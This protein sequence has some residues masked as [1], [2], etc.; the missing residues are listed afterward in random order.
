MK[1]CPTLLLTVALSAASAAGAANT[2][3]AV[4]LHFVGAEFSGGAKD[5]FGSAYDGEQVNT[6]YAAP[7]KPRCTMQVQ[8]VLPT[9]PAGPLF[10]HLK[11]RDDDGPRQCDIRIDL[12][13]QA[14]FAGPNEFPARKFETRQFAI[15]EGA[16]QAGTNTL[17]ITCREAQGKLGNPPW[18]QVANCVIA[19]KTFVLRPD[20]HKS[21]HVVLAAESRPFPEPLPAGQQPGFKFRGTKGWAWTPEQYL[22]EIPWLAKFK[23]NFLM[24]CYLSMFDLE[25]CPN[26]G[27]G[28]AN[29]WWEEL[30]TD[31]KAAYAKVVRACQQQG[32]EF[33]FGMNP[34]LA[35]KRMV[36]DNSPDSVNLLFK[37]Y[38][39]MQSLGVKWFNV[40]LDDISQGINASSQAKV[41]N[42]LFQRLR[43]KDPQAQ[44]I[45][46]PTFYWGD[47]TLPKQQPYLEILA[48]ELDKDVY[49]FWTGD[50]V[51]GKVTRRA[52]ETFRRISGHRLFLWDNYPVNDNQPTL[53]LGPVVDRDADLGEV[54]DG[55]MGNPHC[56]QNEIN[57]LP[58]ATCADYAYN[59]AAYDP[60]RSIGQ[61]ICQVGATSGQRQV[62]RDLVE[63]YPGM[64]IYSPSRGT[65]F[66]SLQDQC[67][68]ILSGP[69]SRQAALAYLEHL[70]GLLQ[71]LKS[72][73]S[74]GYQPEKATLENDLQQVAKK[75]AARYP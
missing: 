2:P 54:I 62:L 73:F 70:R 14:L 67:D 17:A 50:A 63:T 75:I 74:D 69:H 37:H 59:P 55:Y 43:A 5:R 39:W 16:L 26:W 4:L 48:R 8:F 40:S 19:A 44:L 58:L 46:C 45:L 3:P 52:A 18:F 36:N 51:V 28:E 49:V 41:V 22:A 15:P 31:K 35:S 7:T 56:K 11:A 33:C 47:G 71:R 24:N 13:G 20:L 27:N 57:R 66:N 25:H 10:V 12:N 61:A 72:E 21:F 30:P 42:D 53:H 32:I 29:R 60:L 6:I 64:L 1:F 65:G 34:N 9:V 38:A 23:M 68:R